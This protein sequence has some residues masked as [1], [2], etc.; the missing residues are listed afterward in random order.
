MNKIKSNRTYRMLSAIVAII[1]LA[2]IVIAVVAAVN[3]KQN[4]SKEGDSTNYVIWMEIEQWRKFTSTDLFE[5][6]LG[7]D[8]WETGEWK[9]LTDRLYAFDAEVFDIENMYARCLQG[10][11]SIEPDI[12]ISD[13]QEDLSGMTE[14]LTEPV[15]PYDPPTDGVRSVSFKCNG[16]DYSVTVTSYCDWLNTNEFFPFMN[17]VLEK[18]GCTKR[19]WLLG[20]GLDQLAAVVYDTAENA[21]AWAAYSENDLR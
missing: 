7:E 15:N 13:V 4:R 18:E 8:N 14:E 16:H 6:A 2:A 3:A 20:D 9:P 21:K 1:L 17:R 12:V 11:Q 19:L 5:K 10:I